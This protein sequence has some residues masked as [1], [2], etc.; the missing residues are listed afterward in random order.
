MRLTITWQRK[1]KCF[2]Y[3][4]N[5]DISMANVDKSVGEF[6]A[7][8]I[9]SFLGIPAARLNGFC[10]YEVNTYVVKMLLLHFDSTNGVGL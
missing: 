4:I 1:V 7:A 10:F 2:I 8:N 5:K 9:G 6:E 3:M